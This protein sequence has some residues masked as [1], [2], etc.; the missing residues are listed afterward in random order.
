M[1]LLLALLAAQ[2][3]PQVSPGAAP[4]LPHESRVERPSSVRA[5][6]PAPATVCP[7]VEDAEEAADAAR[8]WLAKAKGAER[9][10]AGECLG[11]ALSVSEDWKEAADAFRTARTAANTPAARARLGAMAGEAALNGGDPAAA[12]AAFEAAGVDAAGDQAMTGAIAVYGARALVALGRQEEAVAPLAQARAA[13]PGDA[14]VWLLSAT[15]SRRLGRLGEAQK[16]IERAAD[17][18]PID[19][20]IGLEA[21][22]IA[23]LAGRDEAARKSWDSVLTVAPTSAAADTARGYLAQL[24]APP[25][26]ATAP[27]R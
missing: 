3:G 17:L 27:G 6:T 8:T 4:P 2:L 12:L 22:L 15:L 16:Q 20:E 1:S 19:P 25:P 7:R 10:S 9:A 23:A 13:R 5:A 24:G 18:L 14:K 11:V 21:G 26:A